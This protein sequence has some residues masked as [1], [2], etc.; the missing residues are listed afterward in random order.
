[1]IFV[2]KHPITFNKFPDG[3]VSANFNPHFIVGESRITWLYDSDAEALQ[4]MYIAKSMMNHWSGVGLFMPYVPNARMDRTESNCDIF[5]LKYFAEFINSI[6]FGQVNILDPHS[7]VTPALLNK[8]IVDDG[9]TY[10]D[11]T[12]HLIN[13]ENLLLCYPDNGAEKK[14]SKILNKEYIY[15]IK[16]R[17]WQTGNITSFMLTDPDR[18]AGRNVLIVDDIC[19]RGGTFMHTA[20]ALKEAGANDIYL[21]VSHC[22]NTIHN[23]DVLNSDLIKH[24]YT[25]NSIYRRAHEK[26][27][28]YQVN[29]QNMQCSIV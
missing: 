16:H 12:I 27:T 2:G 19:S 4:V 1:M 3:T 7:N 11:R 23:G 15:G 18:V 10:I 20:R 17:D 25:T 8:V 29:A 5:T 6:G 21:H 22:E 24:V 13:D 26:I 14:Y 28:I 9:R